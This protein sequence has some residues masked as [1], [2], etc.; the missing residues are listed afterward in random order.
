MPQTKLKLRPG[1]LSKEHVVC[2]SHYTRT[3]LVRAGLLARGMLLRG[4]IIAFNKMVAEVKKGKPIADIHPAMP[5]SELQF[6]LMTDT[7]RHIESFFSIIFFELLSGKWRFPLLLFGDGSTNVQKGL[8]I[9][10]VEAVT[11]VVDPRSVLPAYHRYVQNDPTH[12]VYKITLTNR[13]AWVLDPAGARMGYDEMLL[14]WKAFR[15]WKSQNPKDVVVIKP[16][17]ARFER[18]MGICHHG[19]GPGKEDSAK[20]E[21][22]V[23]EESLDHRALRVWTSCWTSLLPELFGGSM[24]TLGTMGHDDFAVAMDEFLAVFGAY[25]ETY[26][27]DTAYYAPFQRAPATCLPWSNKMY[28]DHPEGARDCDS[29]CKEGFCPGCG[30]HCHDTLG[31]ALRV[32]GLECGVRWEL[33]SRV[34]AVAKRKVEELSNEELL[35][36]VQAIL[37]ERAGVNV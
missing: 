6:W 19:P 34:E 2:P 30:C 10:S 3:Y 28:N 17:L 36:T 16:D 12:S 20:G 32:A 23:N 31:R 22:F 27:L 13:Q 33:R 26:L 24:S 5:S 11:Y 4:R 29:E 7:A 1:N 9:K 15:L 14:P 21:N 25:V 37:V 8:S 35:R 18:L